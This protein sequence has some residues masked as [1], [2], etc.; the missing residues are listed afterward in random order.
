M[1]PT[2]LILDI[3]SLRHICVITTS[4][5]W[6]HSGL[7]LSIP[8]YYIFSSLWHMSSTSL[9]TWC[10]PWVRYS[11]KEDYFKINARPGFNVGSVRRVPVIAIKK[12]TDRSHSEWWAERLASRNISPTFKDVN[13]S[14]N[15]LLYYSMSKNDNGVVTK[16]CLVMKSYRRRSS[17]WSQDGPAWNLQKGS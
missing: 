4:I 6:P 17:A 11:N 8:H 14:S 3:K 16:V 5:S 2:N 1:W 12:A 9:K 15:H 10:E 13:I 7:F